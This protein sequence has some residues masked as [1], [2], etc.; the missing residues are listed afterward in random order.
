MNWRPETKLRSYRRNRWRVSLKISLVPETNQGMHL[1][2]TVPASL[3]FV[4]GG[5]R[6]ADGLKLAPVFAG[7]ASILPGQPT[8]IVLAT[9]PAKLMP[10]TPKPF[11]LYATLRWGIHFPFSRVNL[12]IS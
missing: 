5:N 3:L 7:V 10:S 1:R 2:P 11:G 4:A 12:R 9:A 6:S 8:H